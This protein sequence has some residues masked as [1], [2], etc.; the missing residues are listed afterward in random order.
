MAVPLRRK[1]SAA[2]LL[3]TAI[4]LAACPALSASTTWEFTVT[5]APADLLYNRL[6][7]AKEM[8]LNMW[9]HLCVRAAALARGRL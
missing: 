4:A 5:A 3:V 6:R 9:S 1:C 8:Q 7:L 2:S